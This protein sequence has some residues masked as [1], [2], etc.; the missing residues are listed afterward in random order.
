MP[1]RPATPAVAILASLIALQAS[2][3]GAQTAEQLIARVGPTIQ[4]RVQEGV[5]AGL[6]I[7]VIAGDSRASAFYGR[8]TDGSPA[9]PDQDTRFEVGSVSKTFTS[10][11]L[12]DLVTL[13]VVSLD[14][15]LSELLP[16]GSYSPAVGRIDLTSLAVHRSGLPRL[17][18][19]AEGDYLEAI[20]RGTAPDVYRFL[21]SYDPGPTA[22]TKVYS[23]AGMEILGH[24][25]E[26]RS[27]EQFT[28]LLQER[29]LD[30]LEMSR[31][32]VFVGDD[33]SNLAAP[34]YYDRNGSGRLEPID[35]F[36][37][38]RFSAASGGVVSTTR[39][40]LRYLEAWLHP[41]NAPETLRAPIELASRHYAGDPVDAKNA[42]ALGWGRNQSS[43][44]PGAIYFDHD[45]LTIGHTTFV[46][47]SRERDRGVVLLTNTGIYGQTFRD[48]RALG[49]AILND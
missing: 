38:N 36:F 45:G 14:T 2:P 42:N 23:N 35:R 41:G 49:Y 11:L 28:T 18:I 25:L 43:R 21:A 30:P 15:R 39:D 6:A 33:R 10:L 29:I 27:G 1:I 17:I 46:L 24:V 9:P 48:F 4:K 19:G 22:G 13:G 5:Y 3:A 44:H 34:H 12:A 7:G 40:M 37:Y 31:T 32:I 47:F 16:A 26:R 8:R 20:A